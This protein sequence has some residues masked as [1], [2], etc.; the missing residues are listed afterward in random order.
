MAIEATDNLSNDVLDKVVGLVS[1]WFRPSLAPGHEPVK[2]FSVLYMGTLLAARDTDASRAQATCASCHTPETQFPAAV[3]VFGSAQWASVRPGDTCLFPFLLYDPGAAS[4]HYMLF[5]LKIASPFRVVVHNS[6]H[7]SSHPLYYDARMVHAFVHALAFDA[8]RLAPHLR[9]FV[10]PPIVWPSAVEPSAQPLQQV[11]AQCGV[12]VLMWVVRALV[13]HGW[14]TRPLVRGMLPVIRYP[15]K[16]SYTRLTTALRYAAVVDTADPATAMDDKRRPEL[17][18]AVR[19]V[20]C[21]V[22]QDPALCSAD[23]IVQQE[24][25]E[26]DNDDDDAVMH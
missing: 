6:L 7:S 16:Q 21:A 17:V 25:V 15:G 24:Q 19:N 20:V 3:D 22:M 12:A 11:S 18:G 10:P 23:F 26:I 4:G 8:F 1:R 13:Q 2:C 9:A 14:R 5:S